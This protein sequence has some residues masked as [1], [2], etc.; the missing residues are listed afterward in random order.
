MTKKAMIEFLSSHFRYDTMSSWNRATSYAR[1]VK[2]NHLTFPSNDVRNQAYDLLQVEGT[3]DECGVN[4]LIREF[5]EEHGYAYQIGFNGRSGGYMV[6][7]QGG[8]EPSGYRSHCTNCGQRNYQSVLMSPKVMTAEQKLQK[9]WLEHPHW[10]TEVYLKEPGVIALKLSREKVIETVEAMRRKYYE[11]GSIWVGT[12]N[13][14]GVCHEPTR[15]NY[16]HTHMKVFTTPGKGMD[17]DADFADWDIESLRSRVKVVKEFDKCCEQCVQAF[18]KY[19][20]HHTVVQRTVQVPKQIMVA[21]EV[22]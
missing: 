18:I 10:T 6:L 4:D 8:K 21:V 1:N 14:C 7:Y 3:F 5:N 16:E 13:T 20:A 11:K 19:A 2:L 17:M 22:D 15:V 12:D 9:Y